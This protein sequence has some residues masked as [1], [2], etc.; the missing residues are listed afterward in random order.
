MLQD[1]DELVYVVL[2]HHWM[3]FQKLFDG[4]RALLASKY[5][6]I[7]V[8]QLVIKALTTLKIGIQVCYKFEE[9]ATEMYT[10]QSHAAVVWCSHC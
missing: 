1:V 3:R 9:I 7:Y 10:T 8:I 5:A 4:A 2:H 6:L